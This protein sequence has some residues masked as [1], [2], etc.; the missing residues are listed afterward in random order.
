MKKLKTK[1]IISLLLAIFS[2]ASSFADCKYVFRGRIGK[3]PIVLTIWTT[4]VFADGEYYYVSQG[5]NKTLKLS[6]N[7]DL[8]GYEENIWYFT[9]TVNGRKNG[10]FRVK[11]D[12]STRNGYKRMIGTYVNVKGNSYYVNLTCVKAIV[13][14]NHI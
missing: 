8:E 6:G 5:K 10:A 11:W 3:Y 9:E 12:V 14:P 4:A 1:I 2:F 7:Y 13:N